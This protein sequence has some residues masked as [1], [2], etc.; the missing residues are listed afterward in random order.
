M[1]PD[2]SVVFRTRR[3]R[4]RDGA[5]AGQAA[6]AEASS[7][8][9]LPRANRAVGLPEPFRVRKRDGAPAGQATL[10]EASSQARLP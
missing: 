6:L 3:V 1:D 9:R 2:V 4:K 8:A 7:A 10:A 5:P